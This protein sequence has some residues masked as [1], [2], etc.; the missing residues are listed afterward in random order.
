MEPELEPLKPLLFALPL[1]L[2]AATP[3]A[4]GILTVI[5]GNSRSARGV[6]H[7]DICPE[8]KFLKD[9]CAFA[10]TAP[11]RFGTT[12]VTVRGVPPGRYAAQIFLDENGNGEVDRGLF[13]MPME[14]VGFSNDAR[15]SFGPPKWADAMFTFDGTGK[16]L[17]IK[18]RYF[19]GPGG[20]DDR[21]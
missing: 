18:L 2:T 16:T 17:H 5:V 20:P 4:P 6:L 11:A 7:V 12:T 14:G 21:R 9:G 8:D 19:L 3:P 15:I 10:G 1:L 13:G